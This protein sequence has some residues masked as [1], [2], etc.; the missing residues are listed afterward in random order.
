MIAPVQSLQGLSVR[1]DAPHKMTRALPEEMPVALSY[2]GSTQAVMMA[3]PG[4]LEDFALGF[5]LSE[6]IITDPSQI[7]SITVVT[8]D[9]GIEAQIWLREDRAEA[10]GRR[11]RYMSGPVG[12]GLCGIDSLDEALR[13]IAPITAQG[14]SLTHADVDAAVNELSRAQPLHSQTRAVHAAGFYQPGAGLLLARED[15]GRHNAL[16]KLIGAMAAR[17]LDG[18]TGAIVITSRVSVEMVQKCAVG[19][20]PILIAIS[21]PTAH[22]VRLA[23][24][25]NLTLVAL[26]RGHG[27]DIFT[28]PDRITNGDR[29]H[30]D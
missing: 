19:G 17:G 6:H 24:A 26:A 8:H 20:A 5:S 11:R 21:A 12:C 1:A 18:A 7:D 9:T 25:A 14:V 15:V 10:L 4:D 2:N 13:P 3:T 27:F 29:P 22:A 23:E 16:D 28:H 30:V